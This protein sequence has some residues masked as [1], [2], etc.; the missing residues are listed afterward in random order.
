MKIDNLSSVSTTLR[1]FVAGNIIIA[2]SF[3][4]FKSEANISERHYCK[5]TQIFRNKIFAV[6]HD[7][8]TSHVQFD[9]ILHLAVF[10]QIERSSLGNVK[11]STEFELA[12][13]GE[14]LKKRSTTSK[15]AAANKIVGGGAISFQTSKEGIFQP[16]IRE[17]TKKPI[18]NQ[19]DTAKDC[20]WNNHH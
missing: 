15:P 6:I 8:N 18:T 13:N 1:K 17:E 7:E 3:Y 9:V 11:Q 4:G 2:I 12:F 16:H 20:G 14:V 10:E 19:V 5:L